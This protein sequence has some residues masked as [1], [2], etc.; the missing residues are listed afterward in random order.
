MAG[1]SNSAKVGK[2]HWTLEEK[3]EENSKMETS[4]ARKKVNI[5]REKEAEMIMAGGEGL[6]KQRSHIKKTSEPD[7]ELKIN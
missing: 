2:K 3:L 1:Q 5:S 7:K 6:K 4:V